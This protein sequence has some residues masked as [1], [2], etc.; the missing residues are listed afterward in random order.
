MGTYEGFKN[1]SAPTSAG[2]VYVTTDEKAL[3]VD[4][5][6]GEGFERVRMGDVIQVKNVAE[7]Q[8]FAPDYNT[9]ALYY[10]I[11]KN[12]LM[13]YTGDGTT[14]SWKQINSVEAVDT[15]IKE[16]A[17]RVKTT[18][19]KIL[20]LENTLGTN[21]VTDTTAFSRIEALEEQM[22][23]AEGD[24]KDLQDLTSEQKTAIE[25]L[26]KAV[27]DGAE[28]LASKV[29]S[30]EGQM[31]TTGDAIKTIN[32]TIGEVAEGKTVVGLIGEAVTAAETDATT[33]AD[34]ALVAAK[35]YA[36]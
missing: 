10:V 23:T 26:Q 18:E 3:Y 17:G 30:L 22:G 1:L 2:T 24:I 12:A 4:V 31:K 36:D 14:H 35:A 16:V 15:L 11:D 13:K 9:N 7:L 8:S 5:P 19:D 27:G 33:K 32:A 21:D 28:G 34:A 25:N 20:I 29:T 6:K